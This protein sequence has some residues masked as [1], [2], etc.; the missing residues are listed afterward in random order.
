M[1]SVADAT[2]AVL[3]RVPRLER[4]VV[5]VDAACRRVLA[6]DVAVG[7]TALPAG[8]RLGPW[9][10]GLIAALGVASLPVVRAPRVALIATGD[11]L[12]DIATPPGPGQLVDSSMHAL[13]AL[14]REAG[15]VADYLGIARDNLGSLADRLAAAR[16]HD[17]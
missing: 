5:P 6:A 16:G 4:E 7:E 10:I 13:A 12:V 15:G 11:E 3:Q 8:T 2:R 17:V 1:L 14:V 9:D